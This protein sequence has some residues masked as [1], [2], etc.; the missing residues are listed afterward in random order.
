MNST[1]HV[2][3]RALPPHACRMST[4]ASC[5]IASTSRLPLSTSNVPN[6]STVSF[7]TCSLLVVD[8]GAR[9]FLVPGSMFLCSSLLVCHSR[10]IWAN[11]E[12]NQKPETDDI[13]L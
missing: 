2:V 10:L 5:S 6:P 4:W 9:P 8:A 3:H 1:R 11:G 7:G 13:N 12:L